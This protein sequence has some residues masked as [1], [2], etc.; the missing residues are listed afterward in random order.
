MQIVRFQPEHLAQ[1]RARGSRIPDLPGLGDELAR[2]KS[3][4]GLVD[5]AAIAAGGLVE[6]WEGRAL[7]WCCFTPGIRRADWGR[8]AAKARA[9]LIACSYRRIEAHVNCDHAAGIRFVKRFGFKVECRAPKFG[10]DGSDHYLFAL[11]F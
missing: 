1:L 8:I 7:A 10:P 11:V 5:G 6:Q 3:F 2:A 4:A 9:E